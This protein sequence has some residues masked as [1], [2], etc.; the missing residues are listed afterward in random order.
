[1]VR[2]GL[3][4]DEDWEI[5]LSDAAEDDAWEATTPRGSGT[6]SEG[7]FF[8]SETRLQGERHHSV[9]SMEGYV[10]QRNQED[11]KY[12]MCSLLSIEIHSQLLL[13]HRLSLIRASM[14]SQ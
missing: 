4:V 10:C 11:S 5:L 12:L 1:M 9:F 2:P 14:L 8:R 3:E 6:T 13:L 7:G